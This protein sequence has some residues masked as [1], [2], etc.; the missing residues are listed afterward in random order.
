MP[1]T[2]MPAAEAVGARASRILDLIRGDEE[3]AALRRSSLR[4]AD[5]WATYTGYPLVAR[6]DLDTDAPVLF[7]EGLKVLALKA[8]VYELTGDDIAAELLVSLPV[9]EMVHAIIAQ[10]GLTKRIF[11]RLG[12][13][14]VHQTDHEEFGWTWGDYTQRCYEAAGWGTPPDR[15]WIDAEETQ[16]RRTVLNVRYQTIGIEPDGRRHSID[17]ADAELVAA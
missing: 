2:A 14:C 15:Y 9:D 10:A 1:T 8:A 11:D 4:Y 13:T 16:R 17:F 12:I 3:F 7:D 6:W 5:C